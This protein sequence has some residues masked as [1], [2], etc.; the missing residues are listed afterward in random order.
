MGAALK[1]HG[2]DYAG[3]TLTVNLAGD[4]PKGGKDKGKGKDKDGQGKGKD[5]KDGKGKSKGNQEQTVCVKGLSFE[6]D[7]ATLRKDF[8]ECGEIEQLR[9][10]KNEE[11]GFRGIAFEFKTKEGF[12]AALKFNEDTYG[13][14]TIYVS[15]AGEGG[16][17]KKGKKGGL[18]TEQKAAKDGSMVE[19]TGKKQTF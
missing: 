3:R 10:L 9:A 19:S 16:K 4:K 18:S 2:E 12:E 8:E 15:K 7:E 11:G 13:G 17:G 5:G 14:R 6:T 1:F